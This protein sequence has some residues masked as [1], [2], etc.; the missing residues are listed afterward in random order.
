MGGGLRRGRPSNPGPGARLNASARGRLLN[1]LADL[2]EANADQ[3]ARLESLDNGKAGHCSQIRRCREDRGLLTAIPP[4]WAD[5]V[6]GKTIPSTA[7]ISLLHASRA[8]GRRRPGSSP[9]NF[10]MF[11]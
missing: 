7:G 9:W 2:I 8:H 11:E 5:K 10:P 6:Q 3:L 1:R 4:G